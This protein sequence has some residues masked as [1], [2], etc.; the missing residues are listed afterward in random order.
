MGRNV[1][2]RGFPSRATLETRNIWVETGH[3]VYDREVGGSNPLSP[4][5]NIQQTYGFQ[6]LAAV[7]LVWPIC[8]QIL[9]AFFVAVTRSMLVSQWKVN[10]ASTSQLMVS[11]Y[12][13][14]ESSRPKQE[15][16]KALQAATLSLMKDNRYRHSFYWAAGFVL[17]GKNH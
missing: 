12:Q 9:W 4:T 14:L 13:K 7:S 6:R 11:F 2:S 10:S 3:S 17:V 8:E 15:K 1:K 16:A 5:N